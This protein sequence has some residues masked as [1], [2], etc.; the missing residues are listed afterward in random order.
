MKFIIRTVLCVL[1]MFIFPSIVLAVDQQESPREVGVGIYIINYSDV[2]ITQGYFTA[3]FYLTLKDK[4]PIED[5]SFEL[6]NAAAMRYGA[7]KQI[8]LIE[9]YQD[10][11]GMYVKIYRIVSIFRFTMDLTKYPFDSQQLEIQLESKK[12]PIEQMIYV[13][14]K[15]EIGID[16]DINLTGWLIQEWMSNVFVHDYPVFNEQY[17]QFSLTTVVHK[18]MINAFVR[19]FSSVMFIIIVCLASFFLGPEKLHIRSKITNVALIVTGM[20]SKKLTDRIPTTG[21]LTFVDKYI[22]LTCFILIIYIFVNVYVMHLQNI[23]NHQRIALMQVYSL[24]VL[25]IVTLLLYAGLFFW[26]L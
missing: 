3:D 20:F 8:T 25:L 18:N 5:D 2:D 6:M 16:S 17:S 11:E 15:E 14:L 23:K 7:Q 22:L 26:F 12:E 9:D 13:P 1:F 4:L 24:P 19:T 10:D 21:Y